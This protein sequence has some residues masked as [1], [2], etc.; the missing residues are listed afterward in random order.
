MVRDIQK[1]SS[2]SFGERKYLLLPILYNNVNEKIRIK[3]VLRK[4]FKV[5][6]RDSNHKYPIVENLLNR[7][8]ASNSLG[9]KRRPESPI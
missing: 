7:D 8:F 4:K 3:S 1:E 5:V 9:E 2:K 6:T